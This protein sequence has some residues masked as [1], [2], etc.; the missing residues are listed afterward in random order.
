[1]QL[2][3]A[4][5]PIQITLEG[6]VIW[7]NDIHPLKTHSPISLIEGGYEKITCD[8]EEHLLKAK[9]QIFVN[10][11][12]MIICINEMHPLKA[13][14]PIDVTEDGIAICV[15]DEHSEKVNFLISVMN[16]GII[17]SVNL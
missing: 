4:F 2:A 14:I 3:K 1:M 8:N 10:D 7:F 13:L 17:I 16:D 9:S 12:G 5:E 11:G 15:N 6:I